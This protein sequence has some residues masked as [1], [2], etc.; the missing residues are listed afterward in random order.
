MLSNWK[1]LRDG[2]HT[3]SSM[4]HY[5]NPIELLSETKETNHLE[6]LKT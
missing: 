1:S 5:W 3:L 6:N 2:R 4:F